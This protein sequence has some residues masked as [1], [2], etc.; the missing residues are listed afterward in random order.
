MELSQAGIAK[1]YLFALILGAALAFFFDML[2][3][4]RRFAQQTIDFGKQKPTVSLR[5]RRVVAF[6]IVF[7]EDFLFCIVA[8]VSLIL[9]FYEQNNG[10]VRPFAFFAAGIGFFLYRVTLQKPIRRLTELVSAWVILTMKTVVRVLLK[11]LRRVFLAVSGVI[12]KRLE[13]WGAKIEK[14]KRKRHTAKM[15]A[16]VEM[17][18]AGLLPDDCVLSRKHISERRKDKRKKY[19]GRKEKDAKNHRAEQESPT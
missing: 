6:V 2:R 13:I 7:L 14:Q 5:K 17:T 18:A 19:Y 4:P 3:L 15:F 16:L 12:R 11:P 9:L 10:K 8:A 1:L